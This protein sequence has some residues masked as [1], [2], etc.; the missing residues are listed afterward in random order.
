[1]KYTIEI[2]GRGG[3]IVIGTVSPKIYQ[4]FEENN[5]EIEDYAWGDDEEFED[6]PDEYRPFYPSEWFEC[7]DIAHE[8]G[9][10]FSQMGI[11]IIDEEGEYVY[12]YLGS[13]DLEDLDVEVK[14]VAEV[15]TSELPSGTAVFIGQSFEKGHF[16]TFTVEDEEFDITKLVVRKVDIE[17][18]ELVTGVEYNGVDLEDLGDSSTDGKGSDFQ[19]F[20]VEDEEDE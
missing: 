13:Y 2:A 14:E 12:Q 18:W 11:S 8:W 19:F 15:Y 3:E 20:L 5:I 17:G 10:E 16:Y 1:M 4:Y 9:A 7:D 6:M